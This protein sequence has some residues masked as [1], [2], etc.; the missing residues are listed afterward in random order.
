MSDK[1]P[2]K[3]ADIARRVSDLDPA[4]QLR[5]AADLLEARN[6]KVALALITRVQ[7]ELEVLRLAGAF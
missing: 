7:Q 1:S 3:L 6:P 2:D 5:L 4:D